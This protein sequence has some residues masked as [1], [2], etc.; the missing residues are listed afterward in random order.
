MPRLLKGWLPN[1]GPTKVTP[2]STINEEATPTSRPEG[3]SQICIASPKDTFNHGRYEAIRQLGAGRYSHVWLARDLEKESFVA[4]K[5]LNADCYGGNHDIF[6]V[7]IV[8][9]ISHRQNKLED[10]SESHVIEFLDV[11]DTES[12][13]GTHRCIVMPVLGCDLDAQARRF[14]GRR[15]PVQI[16]KQITRQLLL[17]L[18]FLHNSCRVIHTGAIILRPLRVPANSIVDLQPSNVCFEITQTEIDRIAQGASADEVTTTITGTNQDCV[19][20]IDLGVASWVDK[21]LSDN[22]QPEHLRAPEVIIG[23]SWGPAVDIWSLGCLVIEFTKGHIAFPGAASKDGAWS[24]ED[25]H[26]AQYMEVLGPMPL[27][28]LQ[29]GSK[30]SKYF[31]EEGSYCS[32][33]QSKDIAG[34]QQHLKKGAAR[35][36][37]W[38]RVAEWGFVYAGRVAVG[39]V[40][41]NGKNSWDILEVGDIWYFP[42][43]AAHVVQGLEDE[44]EYLLVFDD[45]N[46]EAA[47]TTFNVDDWIAHTPKDILAKNF[48]VNE[49][50]FNSVPATN[51]V[52]AAGNVSNSTVDHPY[53][54]LS[55]NKSSSYVIHSGDVAPIVAPGGGGTIQI[56]DSRSFPISTTIAASVVTIKPGGLRE[57][58]WHPTAE[59]WV[60]FA[61]GQARA[62]IFTGNAAARTFDF[63]AGDTA[64]FPDNSG[65]YVI[66]TSETEDLVWIEIFKADRVAD[67]S[68]TQW[69]ALTPAAVVSQILNIS[70]DAVKTLKKQ[71]QL[72]IA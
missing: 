55:A 8:K 37:H 20:I 66:N 28:L 3:L 31:D 23:A 48:G 17:G 41:E 56:F 50:I 51:P 21:H 7:D 32:Q 35:E 42:K 12:Q 61:Q 16:M 62:T 1:F 30:T 46:F 57:L 59:E 38:H 49:S 70:V 9:A 44:N 40:D 14:P 47:G 13:A 10:T 25:D 69:L 29:R 63:A 15:V 67:I 22:I 60:Y 6:E 58:H 2:K 71:K 53:G 11:F 34:A 33:N 52:I 26:L 19:R 24:S 54:D 64:V 43:G 36:M 72:I 5:L 68:L 27:T 18:E 39:A 65:H 45:G 4:L